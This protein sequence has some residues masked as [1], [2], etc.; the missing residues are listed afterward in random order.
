MLVWHAVFTLKTVGLIV[1]L[2]HA[3]DLQAATSFAKSF[4]AATTSSSSSEYRITRNHLV[5][6]AHMSHMS[7]LL[8]LL[9]LL[10]LNLGLVCRCP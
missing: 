6:R 5:Y 9:L 2:T 8:L 1:F 3:C 10:L 7:L 4:C